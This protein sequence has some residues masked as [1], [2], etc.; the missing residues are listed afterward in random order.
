[1]RRHHSKPATVLPGTSTVSTNVTQSPVVPSTIITSSDVTQFVTISTES[2]IG[3]T[4]E[5]TP[6][7]RDQVDNNGEDVP[8][9]IKQS[10]NYGKSTLIIMTGPQEYQYSGMC[11]WCSIVTFFYVCLEIQ[12]QT[13]VTENYKEVR[14]LGQEC[15][16][17]N[18]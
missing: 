18:C 10:A 11:C 15:F 2:I 6:K 12:H 3:V 14:K 8:E 1:M 4:T 7:A 5:C 17:S 9:A 13:C 16:L